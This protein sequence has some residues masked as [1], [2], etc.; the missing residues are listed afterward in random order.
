M[1]AQQ[2]FDNMFDQSFPGV[3]GVGSASGLHCA[4]PLTG[5]AGTIYSNNVVL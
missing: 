2:P 1:F 4:M 3:D 5:G